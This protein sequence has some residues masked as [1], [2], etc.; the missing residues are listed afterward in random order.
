MIYI[1]IYIYTPSVGLR[2]K[3][4]LDKQPPVGFVAPLVIRG[5]HTIKGILETS[6][7]SRQYIIEGFE[8]DPQLGSHITSRR[9]KN[10]TEK[11]SDFTYSRC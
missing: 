4:R 1:Y 2:V 5:A 9:V 10:L 11:K 7:T 8:G 6:R 3:Q